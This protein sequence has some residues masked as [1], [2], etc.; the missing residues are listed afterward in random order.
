MPERLEL[1]CRLF[2]VQVFFNALSDRKFWEVLESLKNKVGHSI[3]DCHCEFSSDLDYGE[4]TFEG[5]RFS[6][7]ED[8]VIISEEVLKL[9]LK[10]IAL[11]Q[12]E[13]FPEQQSRFLEYLGDDVS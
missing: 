7:Y 9:I 4:E 1:E 3:N 13:K 6:I 8:S 5:V 10:E 12:I 11:K 2:P